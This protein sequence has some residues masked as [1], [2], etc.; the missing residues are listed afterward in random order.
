[1]LLSLAG[2]EEQKH[3]IMRFSQKNLSYIFDVFAHTNL[4]MLY[5]L[6]NFVKNVRDEISVAHL[7]EQ[8]ER[9]KQ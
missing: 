1:M 8:L 5:L 2:D 9:G 6:Y 7:R 4:F 3:E